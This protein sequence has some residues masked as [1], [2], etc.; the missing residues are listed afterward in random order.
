MHERFRE[1]DLMPWEQITQE[2]KSHDA[3]FN[4]QGGIIRGMLKRFENHEY[5]LAFITSTLSKLVSLEQK[6]S[7]HETL[8]K[9]IIKEAND[10]QVKLDD[11][12]VAMDDVFS[13]MREG[14]F[15]WADILPVGDEEEEIEEDEQ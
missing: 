11:L 1:D 14:K 9:N 3:R 5:Q 10:Q 2:L 7:E 4:A 15:A 6:F 8:L 12:E 13:L